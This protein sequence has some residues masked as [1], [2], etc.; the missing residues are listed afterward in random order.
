[1]T[2]PAWNEY[3]QV[4][5]DTRTLR[6][7]ALFVALKGERFDGHDHLQHALARGA[8]AAL[9]RRG[10]PPVAGLV[11]HEVPDTL[12]AYGLLARERR[13]AMTGPVVAVTGSNGK[14]STKEM[15]AGILRT[16][17]RVHATPRNDNNL[18]GIPQ[19]IL[20][21]PAETEA[22]VIEAGANEL[23][24]LARARAI[25]EPSVVVVT[26][27]SAS[28]LA[29]FGSLER[30]LS[31]KLSLAQG[32]PLT[33]VGLEPPALTP[34][35]RMVSQRV[36]TAG[37][38]PHADRRPDRVSS[39][40]SGHAT[41]EIAGQAVR[42]P[43]LGRHQA[44]NAMLA[45]AVGLELGLDAAAMADAL[46]SFRIPGGRGELMQAGGLTILNDC[47]NAN[48]ASFRAAIASAAALRGGRRLVFV[49]GSMRELGAESARLHQEIAT[50]LLA[51]DPELLAGVGEFVAAL[52]PARARLGER[53]LTAPDAESM[54]AALA[55]RLQGNELIVLKASRGV[56][57]E[58]ILPAL[59]GQPAHP[60]SAH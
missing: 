38:E 58:R 49:A 18:V 11:L 6:P 32:A 45:W 16:R 8:R 44:A 34:A 5:T 19:T 31:E 56:A 10:T 14:T 59:T 35:A 39:D 4:S 17:Y 52:E 23:G 54:G 55:P 29:G 28:H 30:I 26:N 2:L 25:I 43:L 22:L 24:E 15:L 33:V 1:M 57:L 21:A 47:Y 13:R 12:Q 53:L 46:R 20:A 50:E 60:L 9:V 36:V 27:V 48:P 41:L 37:L 40:P 51:L 7:G 42:L 3:P